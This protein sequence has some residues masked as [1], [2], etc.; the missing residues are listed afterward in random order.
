MIVCVDHQYVVFVLEIP[1]FPLNTTSE[2]PGVARVPKMSW[3]VSAI[4][5]EHRPVTE[6]QTYRHMGRSI[7]VSGSPA[8]LRQ[9][10]TYY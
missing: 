6:E 5:I 9:D 2:S 3:I 7:V 4:L 10:A 8:I 1:E